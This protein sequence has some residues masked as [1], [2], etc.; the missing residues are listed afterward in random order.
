MISHRCTIVRPRA[1]TGRSRDSMRCPHTG[2]SVPR[3]RR[4]VFSMAIT[5]VMAMSVV[6]VSTGQSGV[7]DVRGLYAGSNTRVVLRCDDMDF[8]LSDTFP[9]MVY[10][11]DQQGAN[12]RAVFLDEAGNAT[13][14]NLSGTVTATGSVSGVYS[15]LFIFPEGQSSESGT[16]TGQINVATGTLTANLVGNITFEFPDNEVIFISCD[17]TN[18]FS[19]ELVHSSAKSDVAI[20]SSVA[21]DPV[22]SGTRLTC[23][24]KITNNGPD[25]AAGVTVASS[26]PNGTSF[27]SLTASQGT[28]TAPD[29]G[30]TGLVNLFLGTIPAGDSATIMLTVNVLAAAGQTISINANV[31]SLSTDPN[32]ANDSTVAAAGV[33]GGAVVKL[34]WDQPTPTADNPT[35]APINLRLVPSGLA[36]ADFLSSNSITAAFVAADESPCTLLRVNVYKS[37]GQPV[38]INPDNL[39]RSVPPDQ[40]QTTMAAAPAGSFFLITNVWQCGPRVVESGGSNEVGVPAGPTISRLKV[41]GKIKAIGSGFTDPPQVFLDGIGFNKP[42]VFGDSTLVVQKGTLT[43]GRSII[44]AVGP[45]KTVV[46]SVRNSNGGI[47][48][49]AFTQQ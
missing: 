20:T 49:M 11:F 42:A 4:L 23:T 12:F 3:S 17:E 26:I 5:T 21:P 2:S 44:D 31:A 24:M 22:A 33:R 16:F 48:S 32:T 36:A 37:D 30:S 19:G 28:F 29:A 41:G 40:L 34:V 35:P 13:G 15:L 10:C 7:P 18:S 27:V 9:I 14:F 46:I 6:A 1:F 38:L 43:D 45:G 39:W 47:S 8:N 25:A